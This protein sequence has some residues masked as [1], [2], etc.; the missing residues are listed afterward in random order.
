MLGYIETMPTPILLTRLTLGTL[1]VVFAFAAGRMGIRVRLG[2]ARMSQL[3]TWMF[4]VLGALLAALWVSWRDP[5][6]VG[7][8]IGVVISAAWGAWLES[9]PKA[10]PEDLSAIIFPKE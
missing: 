3:A 6:A 1:A 2:T 7:V 9:R 10:V 5:V 8:V 4:R